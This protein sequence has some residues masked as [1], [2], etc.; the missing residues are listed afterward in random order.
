MNVVCTGEGRFVEVQGTAEKKPFSDADLQE[1]LRLA[2]KGIQELIRLQQ[3]TLEG[4]VDERVMQLLP[5]I[6]G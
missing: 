3:K 6:R 1:M 2:R 4:I 5:T